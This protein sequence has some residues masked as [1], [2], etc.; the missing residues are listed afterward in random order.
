MKKQEEYINKKALLAE[1]N[2]EFKECEKDGE[3]NGGEAVLLA[4]GI[5]SAIY[6]IKDFPI[7]D[8][9]LVV[10]CRDCEESSETGEEAN[11]LYC[12]YLDVCVNSNGF[13]SSGKKK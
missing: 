5:E 11:P 9:V 7:S 1:L 4:E 12:Q 10:R 3:E 6:T 8:A 13:C 2:K